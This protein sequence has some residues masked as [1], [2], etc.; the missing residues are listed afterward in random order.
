MASY[1]SAVN[2]IWNENGADSFLSENPRLTS[3]RYRSAVTGNGANGKE[4]SLGASSRNRISSSRIPRH[5]REQYI[6]NIC[7]TIA[8]ING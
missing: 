4:I 8:K 7:T 6:P 1:R 2:R 5:R 3:S